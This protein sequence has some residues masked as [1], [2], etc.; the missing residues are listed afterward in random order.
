MGKNFQPKIFAA[1]VVASP[2]RMVNVP[3]PLSLTVIGARGLTLGSPSVARLKK[4]YAL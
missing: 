2:S 4:L 3:S 1:D